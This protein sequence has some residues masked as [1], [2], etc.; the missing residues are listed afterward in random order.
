M[1]F[2]LHTSAFFQLF[3]Q[4]RHRE[5]SLLLAYFK[6]LRLRGTGDRPATQTSRIS[7]K[8]GSN[9]IKPEGIDHVS[10]FVIGVFLLQKKKI[11]WASRWEGIPPHGHSRF[12]L[13]IGHQ[14]LTQV[15]AN[16]LWSSAPHPCMSVIREREH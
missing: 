16:C 3:G 15:F 7:V 2:F 11:T 6:S 10:C 9:D 5:V 8:F 4:I 1:A 12:K 13:E 14:S